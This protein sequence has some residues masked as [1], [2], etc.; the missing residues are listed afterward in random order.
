MK[1]TLIFASIIIIWISNLRDQWNSARSIQYF[2]LFFLFSQ[3]SIFDKVNIHNI[4]KNPNSNFKIVTEW[5]SY[6][7][8]SL[9]KLRLFL[10]RPQTSTSSPTCL[11]SSRQ[12]IQK[13]MIFDKTMNV[14]LDFWQNL[15]EANYLVHQQLPVDGTPLGVELTMVIFQ[16]LFKNLKLQVTKSWFLNHFCENTKLKCGGPGA[17]SRP[18]SPQ[19]PTP[20]VG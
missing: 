8:V 9:A 1:I 5:C 19:P 3:I 11:P 2:F 16:N 13:I 7:L 12:K 6:Q 18:G 17:W 4:N 10:S 14:L 20:L 15:F